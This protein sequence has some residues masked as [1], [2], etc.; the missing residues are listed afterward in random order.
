MNRRTK[1]LVLK[2]PYSPK[3]PVLLADWLEILALVS[4]DGNS[5]DG[6]LESALRAGGMFE[7]NEGIEIICLDTF[8][9]LEERSRAAREAYPFVV[10]NKVLQLRRKWQTNP[11]YVFC[12]CLSY[13]GSGSATSG[14]AFPRRWFEHIS[15]DAAFNYLGTGGDA[16]RFGSPRLPPE[17]PAGFKDS[18]NSICG[19]LNEGQGFKG[20]VQS[21][22]DDY[23]DIIAWKHFPDRLPGKIILFG[24]CASEREWHGGKSRELYPDNFCSEWM[25]DPPR[26]KIVKSLFIPHRPGRDL[27]VKQ[28]RY[29]GIIFDRCRIAYFTHGVARV[30]GRK[31]HRRLFVYDQMATWSHKQL[32]A[33]TK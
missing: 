11:A 16:V 32:S 9:E 19:L 28:L 29:A 13:L 26:C 4:P 22:K 18:I 8:R 33:L 30:R 23:V 21:E 5:S 3:D 10:R 1:K 17:L 27:F 24:N 25:I 15:R 7:N 14:K 6:E 20:K 12:L 2:I 31:K